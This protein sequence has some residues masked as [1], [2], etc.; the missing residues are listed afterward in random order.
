MPKMVS[1]KG[2]CFVGLLAISQGR[3]SQEG[4]FQAEMSAQRHR[5]VKQRSFKEKI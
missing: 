1:Q 2:W 3:E 4:P 5:D